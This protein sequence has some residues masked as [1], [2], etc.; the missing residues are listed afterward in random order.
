MGSGTRQ[1][2]QPGVPP[3]WGCLPELQAGRQVPS[4]SM[5]SGGPEASPVT[6]GWTRECG[7][8]HPGTQPSSASG[9]GMDI[10]THRARGGQRASGQGC[11]SPEAAEGHF[12]SQPLAPCGRGHTCLEGRLG[13]AVIPGDRA[14]H[15][16]SRCVGARMGGKWG[17]RGEVGILGWGTDSSP[18]CPSWGH[19]FS[20]NP[21]DPRH[22]WGGC[23][24]RSSLR[25]SPDPAPAPIG[26]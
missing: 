12:N 10:P 15:W 17:F 9:P 18:G 26:P 2:P 24:G 5:T 4:A 6:A 16:K 3:H 23:R 22:Q 7:P 19:H 14:S 11:P 1:P 8:R 20:A 13:G 25:P 21:S